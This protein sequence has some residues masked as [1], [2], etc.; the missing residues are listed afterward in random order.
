MRRATAL[1][2]LAVGMAFG[3]YCE[4]FWPAFSLKR[5]QVGRG[6]DRDWRAR[7][8]QKRYD[9][10]HTIER[11]SGQPIGVIADLQGPKPR[12]GRFSEGRDY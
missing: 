12:L 10:I 2:V 6:R 11:E 5:T 3:G 9:L 7:G 4:A 1:S 8:S